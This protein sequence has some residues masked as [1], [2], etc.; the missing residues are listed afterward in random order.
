M[1]PPGTYAPGGSLGFPRRFE[2]HLEILVAVRAD[3]GVLARAV[4]VDTVVKALKIAKIGGEQLFDDT[5][6]D[7]V[8]ITQ[9]G[10]NPRKK[11][12]EEVGVVPPHTRVLQRQ[13]SEEHT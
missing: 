10:N 2:L 9:S 11:D 8:E 6:V 1:L 3:Y 12:H 5:R 7:I 13:R 4:A